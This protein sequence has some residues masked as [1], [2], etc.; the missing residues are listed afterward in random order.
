MDLKRYY[1]LRSVFLQLKVESENKSEPVWVKQLENILCSDIHQ[2]PLGCKISNTHIKVGDVHLETFYEAEVLFSHH[3]WNSLFSDWL[4]DKIKEVVSGKEKDIYVI[5]YET[6]IEPVLFLLKDCLKKNAKINMHYGIYEEPKFTQNAGYLKTKTNIRYADD[7]KDSIQSNS[8]VFYLCG[9]STTLNTFREMNEKLHKEC[10]KELNKKYCFSLIQ[11]LP[12]KESTVTNKR[13]IYGF[14]GEPLTLTSGFIVDSKSTS[15]FSFS[16]GD[17]YAYSI[18]G[19]VEVLTRYLV[20]VNSKWHSAIDCDL[21]SPTTERAIIR[22]S[23]TSVVPAQMIKASWVKS[24]TDIPY[25]KIDLFKKDAEGNFVFWNYLYYGHVDRMDHHYIY[26]VRNAHLIRDILN[27]KYIEEYRI[28]RR[29]CRKIRKDLFP[30]KEGNQYVDIIVFPSES[31]D[32]VFPSAINKFV[33]GNNAHTISVDPNKEFRSNFG[34][35]HSNI[36][37]FLE[38][39]KENS[40]VII[41]FHYV[42]KHLVGAETFNRI[43]SLVISLMK[44]DDNNEGVKKSNPADLD[45]TN[46]DRNARIQ[47]SDVIVF[48]NRNSRSSKP[49]Y[50][51]DIRNYYSFIDINVP[52]IRRYGDACPMC[53]LALDVEGFEKCSMLSINSNTWKQKDIQYKVKSIEEAKALR[54][55]QTKRRIEEYAFKLSDELIKSGKGEQ[56]KILGADQ[57][58]GIIA[59]ASKKLVDNF[60]G[61][62][63]ERI[64]PG[65]VDNLS[66]ILVKIHTDDITKARAKELVNEQV[67]ALVEKQEDVLV[68]KPAKAINQRYFRR[69]YLENH[70]FKCTKNCHSEEAYRDQ[71]MLGLFELYPEPDAEILISFVKVISSPYLYYQ[72]HEKNAA[73]KI[74]KDIAEQFIDFKEQISIENG[75][76]DTV[77]IPT[78]KRDITTYLLLIVCLNCL[79]KIDS[80]FLLSTDTIIRLCNTVDNF[81]IEDLNTDKIELLVFGDVEYNC[82]PIIDSARKVPGFLSCIVNNCKRIICGISGEAR[83]HSFELSLIKE[84]QVPSSEKQSIQKLSNILFLENTTKSKDLSAEA[85]SAD[86]IDKYQSSIVSDI[87]K[88]EKLKPTTKL[89]FVYYVNNENNKLVH[90]FS[91]DGR[92]KDELLNNEEY[93]EACRKS[94]EKLLFMGNNCLIYLCSNSDL[95]SHMFLQISFNDMSGTEYLSEIRKCLAYSKAII[96][97]IE[98]DLA[99]NSIQL[100]I[101]NKEA[102]SLMTSG[103]IVSHGSFAETFALSKTAAFLVKQWDSAPKESFEKKLFFTHACQIISSIMDRCIGFGSIK[104][105]VERYAVSPNYVNSNDNSQ[106]KLQDVFSNCCLPVVSSDDNYAVGDDGEDEEPANNIILD[107]NTGRRFL[108]KYLE[109][110]VLKTK[111][112]Y[113]VKVSESKTHNNNF[114]VTMYF[115][116]QRTRSKSRKIV[117]EKNLDYIEKIIEHIY[118]INNVPAFLNSASYESSFPGMFLIGILDILLR[119]VYAHSD[120]RANVKLHVILREN[121]YEFIIT[122]KIKTGDETRSGLTKKFFDDLNKIAHSK[123]GHFN[124]SIGGGSDTKH[125]A[126]FYIEAGGAK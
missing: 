110:I 93:I 3:Y 2:K 75:K 15:D 78:S 18:K 34:T 14:N 10:E 26:Y 63:G 101:S 36:V 106:H 99:N 29:I 12:D 112:D 126:K 82:A 48:L 95:S 68:K 13:D 76:G 35:K 32:E 116:D 118:V 65:S 88:K 5:G 107:E 64:E 11:V 43:K 73:L 38:Q 120:Q 77:I 46:D 71:I 24:P 22:T 80:V 84:L 87:Q 4:C 50:I 121:S 117:T 20:G 103:K 30:K 72:E 104:Q 79:S 39:A 97:T 122:N 1:E 102:N 94:G 28:F 123:G 51:R 6:Y 31:G 100:A 81:H 17:N 61:K 47:I 74:V 27:Y 52:S 83:T 21:C 98:P 114:N 60:A 33:F 90:C 113:W 7:F 59:N 111:S 124:V 62:T 105:F 96:E 115:H 108:K 56:T 69:F 66:E 55:E 92:R 19:G 70:L 109:S 54:K 8:Y 119:N 23:E 91:K 9:I 49:I 86:I 85:L 67:K 53:K 37:Y 41:R 25:K 42:A 89:F 40:N 58:K 45:K 57:K 44:I 16:F 125:V